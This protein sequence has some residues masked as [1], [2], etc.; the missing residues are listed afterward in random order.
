MQEGSYPNF[1]NWRWQ[2]AWNKLEISYFSKYDLST[3]TTY[4]QY[5]NQF[6]MV[7][8]EKGGGLNRAHVHTDFFEGRMI[9]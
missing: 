5:F 9:P 3:S 7:Q 1:G 2:K 8:I 4:S 6:Q